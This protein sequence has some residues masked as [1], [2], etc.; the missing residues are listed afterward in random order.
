[1]SIKETSVQHKAYRHGQQSTLLLSGL[2]IDLRIHL[3]REWHSWELFLWRVWSEWPAG[4]PVEDNTGEDDQSATEAIAVPKH[5]IHRKILHIWKI[6]LN[7]AV[8][9]K[10][11]YTDFYYIHIG[12]DENYWT[13]FTGPRCIELYNMTRR[14]FLHCILARSLIWNGIFLLSACGF[15]IN[16]ANWP[17]TSFPTQI[18][19]NCVEGHL[20]KRYQGTAL[21]RILLLNI[22]VIP[23][24][25]HFT[26]HRPGRFNTRKE[27]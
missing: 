7:V 16:S 3:G 15:P 10:T 22:L 25:P 11:K 24:I 17:Q 1:M 12:T 6:I 26:I 14:P 9:L 8:P 23:T 13:V 5:R 20:P 19:Q 4:P 27:F 21:A 18:Y 2:P